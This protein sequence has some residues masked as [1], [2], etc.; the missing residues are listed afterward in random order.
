MLG[1]LSPYYFSMSRLSWFN[2]FQVAHVER[3][4]ISSSAFLEG[5]YFYP[6]ASLEN[7]EPRL[8]AIKETICLI[9]ERRKEYLFLSIRHTLSRFEIFPVCLQVHLR[10]SRFE[11]SVCN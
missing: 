8:T 7:F 9:I 2:G 6:L 4:R 3:K 11:N 5:M 10:G 1:L